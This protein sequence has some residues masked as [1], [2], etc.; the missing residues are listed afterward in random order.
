M[1]LG[2]AILGWASAEDQTLGG[3]KVRFA[4]DAEDELFGSF[5]VGH[6]VLLS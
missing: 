4:A 2:R 3:F 6:D 1:L 5:G